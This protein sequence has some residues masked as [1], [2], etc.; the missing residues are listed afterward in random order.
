MCNQHLDGSLTPRTPHWRS[1]SIHSLLSSDT[2]HLPLPVPQPL[3]V[4]FRDNKGVLLIKANYLEWLRK[5]IMR[6]NGNKWVGNVLG[7][8]LVPSPHTPQG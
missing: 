6:G 3:F 8:V 7:L 2:L 4:T 5:E 1:L